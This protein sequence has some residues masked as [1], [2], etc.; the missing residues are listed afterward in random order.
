MGKR[1]EEGDAL[2]GG[3]FIASR[4]EIFHTSFCKKEKGHHNRVGN[5]VEE[6]EKEGRK[7]LF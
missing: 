7:I 3:T 4:G 2:E 5:Q 6:G 1:E